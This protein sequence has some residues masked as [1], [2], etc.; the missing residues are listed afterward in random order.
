MSVYMMWRGVSERTCR[1]Q[2][3]CR[4]TPAPQTVVLRHEYQLHVN[5]PLPLPPPPPH[6]TPSRSYSTTPPRHP[7]PATTVWA[8]SNQTLELSAFPHCR[9]APSVAVSLP[10]AFR[11]ALKAGLGKRTSCLITIRITDLHKPVSNPTT[12]STT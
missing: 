1:C 11:S 5:S 6:L 9:D 2:P 3:Y 4:I 12:I 7:H 10:T 8:V